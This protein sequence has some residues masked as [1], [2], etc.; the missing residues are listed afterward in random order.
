M[1]WPV[2]T[3][4]GDKV[5][6]ELQAFIKSWLEDAKYKGRLPRQHR[7]VLLP[8]ERE[9]AGVV[10]RITS[11]ADE[12]PPWQYREGAK[13]VV[14]DYHQINL[15]VKA[16]KKAGG[17]DSASKFHG[18]LRA[19]FANRDGTPERLDLISRGLHMCFETPDGLTVDPGDNSD[20]GTSYSM[21]I[22]LKL[23]TDTFL[24]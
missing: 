13:D 2:G 20:E 1:P 21:Q 15:F 22:S 14:E 18:A 19:M 9:P 10:V 23:N 16:D 7:H 8:G 4:S 24:N 5:R 11:Q 6:R 12:K 3:D 17:A